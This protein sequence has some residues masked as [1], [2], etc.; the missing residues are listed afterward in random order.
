M[1]AGVSAAESGLAALYATWHERLVNYAAHYVPADEAEDVVQRA[2]IE[3]WN[4][5]GG[6]DV[7]GHVPGLLIAVGVRRGLREVPRVRI[8]RVRLGRNYSRTN[9]AGRA[10]GSKR[11]LHGGCGRLSRHQRRSEEKQRAR[12][13]ENANA[14]AAQ[15]YQC[16]HQKR[17][18]VAQAANTPAVYAEKRHCC[19]DH[20][21][22][23]CFD[24][25][26]PPKDIG[27]CDHRGNQGK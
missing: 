8:Q 16:R 18:G 27:R 12:R 6:K 20:G 3:L 2:F 14:E 9:P 22:E 13:K 4:R 21:N 5:S 24:G 19:D 17:G 23:H 10:D 26:N 25:L 1:L 7:H 11:S 15:E